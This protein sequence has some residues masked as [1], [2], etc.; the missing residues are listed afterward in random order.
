MWGTYY[1]QSPPSSKPSTR[2]AKLPGVTLSGPR[3]PLSGARCDDASLATATLH[4]VGHECNANL[5][6][7]QDRALVTGGSSFQAAT[8]SQRSSCGVR[9]PNSPWPQLVLGTRLGSDA[10]DAKSV[11]WLAASSPQHQ[12]RPAMEE[13]KRS[14]P[15]QIT[16][17]ENF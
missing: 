8:A 9:R 15:A 12:E 14:R 17:F 2:S 10:S 1:I 11:E 16:F 4:L 5:A 3:M 13:I 7:L 6:M